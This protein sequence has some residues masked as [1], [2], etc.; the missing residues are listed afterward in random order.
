MSTVGLFRGT[1]KFSGKGSE[2]IL[3]GRTCDGVQ[4]RDQQQ[5]DNSQVDVEP[6]S[7]VDKNGTGEHVG[8]SRGE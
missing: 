2:R 8:L 3:S 1:C 4:R 7:L 6:K 5:C